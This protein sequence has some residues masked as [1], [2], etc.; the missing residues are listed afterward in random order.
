MIQ[1]GGV[2]SKWKEKA[3]SYLLGPSCFS[4]AMDVGGFVCLSQETNTSINPM[5]FW[6]GELNAA[7]SYTDS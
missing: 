2:T 7:C 4:I 1:K 6:F 5:I 3:W